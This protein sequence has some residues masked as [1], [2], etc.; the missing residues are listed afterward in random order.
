LN[1]I[2]RS[3]LFGNQNFQSDTN[4]R[5]A[6]KAYLS[7]LLRSQKFEGFVKVILSPTVHLGQSILLQSLGLGVLTANTIL[8][9]W[10]ISDSFE[11]AK[12]IFQLWRLAQHLKYTY[13]L[14]KHVADFPSCQDR[15]V[16]FIDVWWIL[17]R[18]PLL[19]L[20]AFTLMQ[21]KTWKKCGIRLFLITEMQASAQEIEAEIHHLRVPLKSIKVLH[22]SLEN[23]TTL[24]FDFQDRE[25][26]WQLT[27]EYARI[28]VH[29]Y[30]RSKETRLAI[31]NFPLSFGHAH[32]SFDSDT[33]IAQYMNFLGYFSEAV[34]RIL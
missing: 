33:F 6:M 20:I 16:G 7:H 29:Q 1:E 24:D 15:E 31:M 5:D 27:S 13:V 9:D 2:E 4:L 3:T 17:D 25:R 18:P 10:P 26:A 8:V 30:S 23:S 34:D 14:S 11:H 32:S 28:C 12:D 21:H 22:M 19:L